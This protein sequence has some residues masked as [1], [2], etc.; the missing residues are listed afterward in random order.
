MPGMRRC[1]LQGVL[2]W[3]PLPGAHVN[4]DQVTN[5]ACLCCPGRGAGRA[6]LRQIF[7]ARERRAPPHSSDVR[8]DQVG[9]RSSLLHSQTRR[10]PHKALRPQVI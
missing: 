3:P 8:L 6:N 7:P 4:T 1:P 2:R 5:Q 10:K 9:T